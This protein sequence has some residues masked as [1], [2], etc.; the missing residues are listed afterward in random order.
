MKIGIPRE[1][2]NNENR[3]AVSPSGVDALVK[4]GHEVVI[5][6]QAG[7][8][9]GFS[10][11]EYKQMGAILEQGP[12]EVW[13][14]GMVIKVK[15]PLPQEYP[16][17]Y[18]GLILLT[19]LHL[20]AEPDLAKKLT[21]SKVI[22][23]AYE[24]IQEKDGSLPLLAPMSQVA[25]RIAAQIGA[26]L[27][28]KPKGGKGVL[29][30]GIPGVM[31]GRVTIIGG[32]VVG[33]NAAR[34]AV[35]LGANVTVLDLDPNR[36]RELENL[37]GDQVN[38]LMSNPLNIAE[39]VAQSDLVIGAVLIPGTKA[40]KLVREETV[41]KMQENSVIVDVAIDQGGI[42]ETS[43]KVTTHDDSTFTKHGVVHYAVANMPGAVPR[44]ASSG[45]TN[46]T[47]PYA[48]EIANKGYVKS[49]LENESIKKGINTMQGFITYKAVAEAHK[50]P[51]KDP[52]LLLNDMELTTH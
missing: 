14:Q 26:Q 27:L 25:G 39:S 22:S 2:K 6:S 10:D 4:A 13:S 7:V 45:L 5:E 31:P 9:S 33:E 47:L 42:F 24:T 29:L 17:F 49:S 11:E 51:Y 1:I 21:D 3:V 44:T 46:V 34:I 52:S 36:L 43:D 12:E 35:G 30:S 50:I 15:E 37:F 32:G 19:Y 18:E 41:K 48:L 28:E 40:P 38:T 16:Y 23:I 20:A 8:G